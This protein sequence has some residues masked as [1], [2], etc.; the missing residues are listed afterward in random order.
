MQVVP[1]G[2]A[3]AQLNSCR[4][5][6]HLHL[7]SPLLPLPISISNVCDWQ[8]EA[9]S[10]AMLRALS[11]A[12]RPGGAILMRHETLDAG[13]FARVVEAAGVGLRLEPGVDRSLHRADRALLTRDIAAAWK[14]A[15][16]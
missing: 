15:V 16:S 12:L 6:N 8:T 5:R 1:G 11:A 14:G 7:P 9:E 2:R 10:V 3:C 4:P 13:F